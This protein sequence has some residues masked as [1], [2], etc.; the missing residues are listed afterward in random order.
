[1]G[2]RVNLILLSPFACICVW[3]SSDVRPVLN[4][5]IRVFG[6][7]RAFLFLS[8]GFCDWDAF[9]VWVSVCLLV[10]LERSSLHCAYRYLVRLFIGVV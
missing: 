9:Q 7:Y 10:V 8:F 2:L 4:L 3:N 5:Q 1:M 6:G